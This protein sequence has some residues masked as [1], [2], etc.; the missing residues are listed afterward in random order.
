MYFD[1]NKSFKSTNFIKKTVHTKML[2]MQTQ[3]KKQEKSADNMA[4]YFNHSTV[5]FN[6]YIGIKLQIKTNFIKFIHQKNSNLDQEKTF[7]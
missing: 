2:Q 3:I 1:A 4:T 5:N 7:T 6:S